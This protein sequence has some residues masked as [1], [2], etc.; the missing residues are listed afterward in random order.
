MLSGIKIYIEVTTQLAAMVGYF[1]VLDTLMPT[2]GKG[3]LPD[4]D[5]K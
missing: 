2:L 3:D 4:I 5:A 1:K